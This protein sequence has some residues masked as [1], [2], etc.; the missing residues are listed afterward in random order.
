MNLGNYES[1]SYYVSPFYTSALHYLFGCFLWGAF[2]GCFLW[3]DFFGLLYWAVFFGLLFFGCF[4]WSAV[5]GLL[6]WAAFVGLLYWAAFFGLL[7][8]GC[9]LWAAFSG[10][11][12]LQAADV[13][14]MNIP[15]RRRP[16]CTFFCKFCRVHSSNSLLI[17]ACHSAQTPVSNWNAL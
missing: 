1:I 2:S 11:L 8:L 9:F 7:F 13:V 12:T 4:L 16:R 3:S 5:F 14:C 17:S 6:Y 10:L 15:S